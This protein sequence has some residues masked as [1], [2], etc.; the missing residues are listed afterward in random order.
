MTALVAAGSRHGSTYE[1]AEAIA[2]TRAARL[3]SIHVVLMLL[4]TGLVMDDGEF[5]SS[6][7]SACASSAA[8]AQQ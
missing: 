5:R 6:R 4:R 7:A 1:I 8:N 2:R 3:L